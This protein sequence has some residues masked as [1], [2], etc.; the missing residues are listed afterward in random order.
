MPKRSSPAVGLSI[1]EMR[2]GYLWRELIDR[3]M[4]CLMTASRHPDDP[5]LHVMSLLN[6]KLTLEDL[7]QVVRDD[8]SG[9]SGITRS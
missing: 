7:I 6:L 3:S 8:A 2:H 1:S 9:S 5:Q 4:S